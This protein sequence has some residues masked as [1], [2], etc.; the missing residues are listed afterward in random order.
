MADLQF[1]Y[2]SD[3]EHQ[4]KAIDAVVDLFQGQEFLS[5]EFSG[6]TG[7]SGTQG[8]FAVG[9][10]NGIRVSPRQLSQNLHLAQEENCLARTE[11]V[12][13]GT[14]RD[15]TVE[16]E[17]GTG[18]TYVYI[19]S[20]YEL[21]KKYGLTKFIIVVPS[22]AIREGVIKSFES[23]KAHFEELY[24]NTPL[25]VFVYDSKN[26]GPVGNFALSSSI[27]VMIINIQAFN[28][29][30]SKEGEENRGNLFHRRSEKLIGGRSPQEL[31]AEC[32]PIVII[33]EPQ[34][35]DNSKQAKAAIKSLSPCRQTAG[36]SRRS[37]P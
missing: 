34:S 6:D 12:T 37:S 11:V 36:R 16:M 21:N 32:N 5:R 15:F 20:I 35:V 29:E 24:D 9:H 19:R 33:D 25:D 13:D 14:L 8:T 3:Q 28:K 22:V 4:K 27:E 26:M 18:K 30:F 23:T 1:K 17:T 10:A 7:R 31:V 2:S